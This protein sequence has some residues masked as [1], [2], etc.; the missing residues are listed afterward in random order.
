MAEWWEARQLM[1]RLVV[2]LLAIT[3]CL[4]GCTLTGSD[5][6]QVGSDGKLACTLVR[7]LPER[8]PDHPPKDSLDH[9]WDI[10]TARL[11]TAAELARVA[12]LEDKKYQPLADAL[13]T[14]EVAFLTTF[15]VHRAEPGIKAARSH[16]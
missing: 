4:S 2:P 16:C 8:M 10:A 13:K 5:G 14:A 15:D 3:L 9:S 1:R 6:G 11:G 7:M 12:A